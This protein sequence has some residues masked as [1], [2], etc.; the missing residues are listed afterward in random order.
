MNTTKIC[1]ANSAAIR[2]P[3]RV[4]ALEIRL[5]PNRARSSQAP[6]L[7]IVSGFWVCFS[8]AKKV[9]SAVGSGKDEVPS[10]GQVE[11]LAPAVRADVA[12]YDLAGPRRTKQGAGGAGKAALRPVLILGLGL[13]HLLLR[14][15]SGDAEDRW[16]AG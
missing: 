6:D 15:R 4:L 11:K 10:I 13:R 2:L 14:G 5:P 3:D 1:S 8:G 12:R 9:F 7:H 16:R